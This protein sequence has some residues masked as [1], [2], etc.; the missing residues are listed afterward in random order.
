MKD[1]A[2]VGKAKPHVLILGCNFAGLTA[3][4]LIREE[5]KDNVDITVVDRKP[6]LV[7]V[8]NIP[9]EVLS[10]HDPIS[11]LH[12]NFYPFLVK[13]KSV[14]LQAEV[15]EINV[16]G[17]QVT[18]VPSERPGAAS[19][20][21]QYDYLVI[22]LG[23]KLDY[24]AIPGFGE[25][26]STVSDTYYGNK[27]RRYLF[28]G[29]YKGGPIAI[30]SCAAKID[31][32]GKPDWMKGMDTYCDG[33][34]LEVSL[35]LSTLLSDKKW[36]TPKNITLFTPGEVIASDAGIPLAKE[37]LHMTVDGM[38][39]GYK[40]NV[41]DVKELTKDGIVFANGDSMEAE[42][43][44]VMPNWTPHTLMKGLSICDSLGY[45]NTDAYMRNPDHPEI[46]CV[47]DSNGL[48]APKLGAFGDMQA[49]VAAKQIAKDLGLIAA[50]EAIEFKPV[51]MCFGD[52]G[53]GK[54]FYIHSDL[55]FGGKMG[56]MKMGRLYYDMKLAFK[57]MYFM[58]G[59]RPPAWG[60]E[61]SELVTDKI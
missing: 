47:G 8:P 10:N 21:L 46:L 29:H 45:V 25:Y 32:K 2:I 26:G 51:V 23:A 39:M 3:A 44:I 36:G 16:D 52:A 20:K 41:G 13:D 33:P 30:G 58:T 57:E 42:I 59:G 61:L 35:S 15:K 60:M 1:Q 19:E 18:I 22:A 34:P 4:R 53:D 27:L 9:L 28:E 50:I 6:Y 54:G 40:N 43:K 56:I 38:G 49:R 37:F 14:F 11:K 12:M 24:E 55:A 31:L 7:F 48:T 5:C 17:K